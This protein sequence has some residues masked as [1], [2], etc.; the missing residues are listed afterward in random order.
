MSHELT[1][2][3]CEDMV[4]WP[5]KFEG[6]ERYLPYY[7]DHYLNGSEDFTHQKYGVYI[8]GYYVSKEDKAKFPELKNRRTVKFYESNDGFICEVR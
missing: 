4:N 8:S 3:E 5:G 6:E 1:V 7:Y 2:Q